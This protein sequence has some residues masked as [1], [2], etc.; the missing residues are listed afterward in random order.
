[1]EGVEDWTQ[2]NNPELEKA[3]KALGKV[4]DNIEN[5]DLQQEAPIVELVDT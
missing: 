5:I 3:I 2:D 4:L 1:M